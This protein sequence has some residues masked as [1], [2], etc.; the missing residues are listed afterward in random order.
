MKCVGSVQKM[1][2]IVFYKQVSG[3]DAMKISAV[4][5]IGRYRGKS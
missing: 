2:H 3:F 5:T 1:H 4:T